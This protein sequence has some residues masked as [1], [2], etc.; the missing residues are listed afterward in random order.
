MKYKKRVRER[1]ILINSETEKKTAI[2][3][4][5]IRHDITNVVGKW[6]EPYEMI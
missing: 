2:L 6:W 4:E 5:K 1:E 3:R